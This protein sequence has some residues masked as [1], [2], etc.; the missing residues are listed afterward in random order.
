V[1][2]SILNV[3]VPFVRGGAEYLADSL[4]EKIA[5]RGHRVD[6]IR[7]PLKSYPPASILDHMLACRLLEP[8][9]GDP[10]V[11][12]ALKFPAYLAPF[13]NKKVWLLHQQRQ[14]YDLWDTPHR[15]LEDA[16]ETD[17]VRAII[18]AAD[19][20]CLSQVQGL[21][22]NSRIV[23]DRLRKFNGIE[24]DGILYPPL[25]DPGLFRCGHAGDYVFYPSRLCGMKRQHVAIEAMC[26]VRSDFRLVLAGKADESSYQRKL[27]DLIRRHRLEDR[28]TLVGWISEEEKARLMADAFAVLYLAIDEDSYGYVTLEAFHSAK[29]VLTFR[30][31]GGVDE[32]VEHEHNGLI[33]EPTPEVLAEGMERLWAD[34]AGAREMGRAARQTLGHKRIEWDHVLDT[35]LS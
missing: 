20:R 1:K 19:D 14:F 8:R 17:R 26:H 10:D 31:S 9:T 13:E 33:L 28:V 12:I 35:L 34:V 25:L 5:A 6:Q 32:L 22:T 4:G 18:R 7:I 24:A 21:Y 16:P 15:G 2:V 30:D 29:P 23:A 3:Q 27:E 11:V